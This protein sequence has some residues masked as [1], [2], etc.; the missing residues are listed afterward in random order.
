[1]KG[2]VCIVT[3][4]TAGIGAVTARAL[5]S[6]GATVIVVGRNREKTSEIVTKIKEQTGN[7]AVEPIMGRCPCGG[8]FGLRAPVRCPS[9]KSTNIKQGQLL[10]Q[11]I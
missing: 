4:A 1:M 3:G 5:A 6:Q 8:Q 10:A 2:K 7:Q 11:Y 9:C